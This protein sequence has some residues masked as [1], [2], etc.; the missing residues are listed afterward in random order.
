MRRFPGR[1]GDLAKRQLGMPDT[2]IV[3]LCPA[4]L[5]DDVLSLNVAKITQILAE[6]LD[7]R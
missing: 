1:A 3:F 4:V 2:A 5:D 6:Y 7:I